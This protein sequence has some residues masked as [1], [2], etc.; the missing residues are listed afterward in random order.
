MNYHAPISRNVPNM[1]SGR[2]WEY[3]DV[4]DSIFPNEVLH[5]WAA[6]SKPLGGQYQQSMHESQLLAF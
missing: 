1:N 6:Q 5:R 2:T 3:F 4:S